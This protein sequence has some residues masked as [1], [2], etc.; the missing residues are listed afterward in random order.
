MISLRYNGQELA[1][2]RFPK[3]W[4]PFFGTILAV[5]FEGRLRL[6]RA[7]AQH[8]NVLTLDLV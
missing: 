2:W 3:G 4:R 1:S 6:F 8:D 7:V 5:P